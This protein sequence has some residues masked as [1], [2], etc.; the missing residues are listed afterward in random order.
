MSLSSKSRHV[1]MIES[2]ESDHTIKTLSSLCPMDASKSEY[3]SQSYVMA[4]NIMGIGAL[5]LTGGRRG[6][7]S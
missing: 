1:G 3:D 4:N 2:I 7:R 6:T 5:P